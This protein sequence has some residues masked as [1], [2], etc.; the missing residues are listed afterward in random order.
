VQDTELK[1]PVLLRER[2][3]ERERKEGGKEGRERGKGEV[4]FQ[5]KNRYF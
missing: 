5:I 1:T 3:R 2:E 4:S